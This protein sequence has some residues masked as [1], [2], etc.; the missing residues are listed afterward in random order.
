M[1]RIDRNSSGQLWWVILLLA[2]AV[3]LPTV[4]LLWFMNSAVENERFAVRQRL[5]DSY[6]DSL[7]KLKEYNEDIWL[8]LT[9]IPAR[10]LSD[11]DS[12]PG[13][14][15]G[16]VRTRNYGKGDYNHGDAV[17]IYDA[18]GTMLYPILK[19]YKP[20]MAEA[21]ELLWQLEFVAEDY[22][23]A[24][25]QYGEAAKETTDATA[26]LHAQIAVVRNLSKAGDAAGALEECRRIVEAARQVDIRQL[27]LLM[28]LRM[29]QIRLSK[30]A[31]SSDYPGLVKQ[32]I[33]QAT[34]QAGVRDL[35]APGSEPVLLPSASRMF[36]LGKAVEF[37]G[38]SALDIAPEKI[39]FAEE[40]IAAEQLS[41]ELAEKYPDGSAIADWPERM[42]R[43]L[44]HRSDLFGYVE[45][46]NRKKA[47]IVFDADNLRLFF[48]I[49]GTRSF[50]KDLD[51]TI[52]DDTGRRVLGL[53]NP[54]A[55]ALL[56]YPVS[57]Y[58]PRWEISVF[59]KNDDLFTSA[60]RKQTAVYMW[61]GS[62]VIIL[63]LTVGGFAG[64]VV[65]RQM[66]LNRLKNDFIATITHELKTPLASMRVL[67]DT[68]L[69]GSYKDQQ[70]ASEY[71]ELICKENKRLTGLIDNF[72]TFSRMERNKQAFEFEPTSPAE[73]V[74][75]AADAVKTKFDN[76]RA[77]AK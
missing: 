24:A 5:V 20:D 66:K 30:D 12:I 76:G 9:D 73:I 59:L 43:R 10:M 62:L 22:A 7:A 16:I 11:S 67:A 69:E 58:F 28:Q 49:Y 48:E 37:A 60:A 8:K 27:S 19:D 3:I 1:I 71:L 31:G 18:N 57:K 13:Y 40:L 61:A 23:A 64:R 4:C 74:R 51:Y 45:A 53:E 41:L 25:R 50:P 21:N 52:T 33:A 65:G 26:K 2:I 70:Q 77:M 44:G 39:Q 17:L 46:Y 63:V 32:F 75:A 55:P 6:A 15:N 47:L 68:L 29:M 36:F 35:S 14:F 72:L 54:T 42:A 56:K 34:E 38:D